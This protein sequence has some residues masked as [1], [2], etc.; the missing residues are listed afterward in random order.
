MQ[1]THGKPTRKAREAAQELGNLEGILVHLRCFWQALVNTINHDGV[2]HAGY[3]AFLGLLSLF[4]FLVLLV[5]FAGMLGEQ[6]IGLSFVT[7]I[8]RNLPKHVVDALMPRVHEIVS[9]PPQGILT[10]AILGAMWTA[11][12]IVEGLRTI[13]NRAYRVHTPPAYPLRRLLSIVQLL[14]V[15]VIVI[16]GMIILVVAPIALHWLE[17][18]LHVTLPFQFKA[19]SAIFTIVMMWMAVASVYYVL[20]NLRQRFV[21]TL[22]GALLAV[23]LWV[24]SGWLLT[25][26]LSQFQQI[27]LIYGSLGG[28]IASLLFFYMTGLAVIYGAEFNYLMEELYEQPHVEKIKAGKTNKTK[29]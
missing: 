18:L 11:S 1:Q 10:I 6:D 5:T 14:M 16:S 19:V 22:P 13:L 3:L 21:A 24:L 7:L 20:P 15:M 2:E 26:Y 25:F 12:S 4:P 27:N 29:T 23:A 17:E 28:I 9:G 8:T